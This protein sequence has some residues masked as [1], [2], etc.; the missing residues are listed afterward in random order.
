MET[1]RSL[2]AAIDAKDSYTK[3]HQERVAMFSTLLGEALNFTPRG[4]GFAAAGGHSAR[5]RKDRHT[6]ADS[7]QNYEADR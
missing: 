4:A 6:R 7:P 1:V 2:V 5:Y 3:G